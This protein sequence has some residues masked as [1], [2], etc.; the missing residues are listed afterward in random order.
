MFLY[1]FSRLNASENTQYYCT[2]LNQHGEDGKV[3]NYQIMPVNKQPDALEAYTVC[4]SFKA[5]GCYKEKIW[6]YFSHD[7]SHKYAWHAVGLPHDA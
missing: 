7:S 2:L 3:M 1:S 5:W 4:K 6:E